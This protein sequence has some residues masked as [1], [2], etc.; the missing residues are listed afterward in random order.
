MKYTIIS[1]NDRAIKNINQNKKI[2]KD[3]EFVNSIDFFNGNIGNAGDVLN[4]RGIPLNKWNP[5]DGRTSDPLPGEYGIWVSLLNCLDYIVDNKED[6]FLVLED[7]ISLSED[8]V[9]NLNL[10]ISELPEDYDFLSLYY[11]EG[12]NWVDESTDIGKKYIHK[13]YNQFSAGQATIFS[14]SGA[15]KILKSLRRIGIEYTTDCFLFKQ[16][17]RGVVNGYSIKPDTLNFLVHKNDVVK[18]LIDPEN[19]RNT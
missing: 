1:V 9:D 12:H 3:F 7:D 2:L 16:S 5:Y 18:S 11:F 8:F 13:S 6:S 15:K 14:Q 17:Q 19:L 4:H 10:C